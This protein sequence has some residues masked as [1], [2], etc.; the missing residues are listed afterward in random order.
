MQREH[1]FLHLNVVFFRGGGGLEWG[2]GFGVGVSSLSLGFYCPNFRIS[3][4][5]YKPEKSDEFQ[6]EH[7]VG[8]WFLSLVIIS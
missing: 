2:W 1:I 3:K 7:Q 6:F 5:L 4:T 8:C